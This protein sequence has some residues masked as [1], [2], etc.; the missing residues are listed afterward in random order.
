MKKKIIFVFGLIIFLG[1]AFDA[2]ADSVSETRFFYT[3]A[4]YDLN[5]RSKIEAILVKITPRAYFYVD[6]TWWSNV[7]QDKVY[8]YLS[9]L[10]QEFENNIYPVLTSTFGSEIKPGIDK[11]LR[12]TVLM[13]PMVNGAGGYF[14]SNDEYSKVQ[15]SDSNE[16]EMVYINS[17]YIATDLAKSL[18]AHEFV[19]LITFNQKENSAGIAEDIWLNEARAEYAPTLL[20]YDNIY[21]GSNLQKRVKIFSEDPTDSIIEWSYLKKD[22]GSV[23]MFIHYLVDH[24]GVKILIDSLHSSKAG[25]ESINY[26]LEENS[27]SQDFSQIFNDWVIAVLVNNCSYGDKYCYLD[28]NLKNFHLTGRINFLPISGESSLTFADFTRKWQGNWYKII[29][30]TDTLEVKFNCRPGVGFK[31]P[32]ITQNSAGNYNIRFLDLGKNCSGDFAVESF[33]ND[34]TALYLIPL[35]TDYVSDNSAFYPFSWTVSIKKNQNDADIIEKL[36]T[37]IA[38][39]EAEIANIQARIILILA[40]KET[41][42]ISG[43]CFS[44][45]SNLYYGLKNQNVACLQQFL[46]LQGSDIYPEGL[47]TG[48]FGS[49]TRTAVIRFQEK[50]ASEILSPLGLN[51][52]TGYVGL[53]TRTKINNLLTN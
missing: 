52:G 22:Y 24:Y 40:G 45:N 48:Y 3:D 37:Q 10:E 7:S 15:V 30:G 53:S 35:A 44:I 9:I 41:P 1:I 12:I 14:R 39:L 47:I 25:I 5:A 49:L 17:D 23:S 32:Y 42:A 20:G 28:K 18:L 29:G 46:K 16:R 2:S 27:F 6:K 19:H 50:Y 26:A 21:E 33:G 38:Q 13:H 51:T 31:L 8:Q 36:L 4:S 43:D 34:V 11:D